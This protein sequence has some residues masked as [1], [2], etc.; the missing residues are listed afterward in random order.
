MSSAFRYIVLAMSLVF[1]LT[2]AGGF[3]FSAKKLVHDLG[4]HKQQHLSTTDHAPSE[5]FAAKLSSVSSNNVDAST[6]ELEHQ[7][8]HAVG[9]MQL[10]TVA[11][12]N[13]FW[14]PASHISSLLTHTHSLPV[15]LLEAPFRPPR[16]TDSN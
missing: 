15:V 4:H 16:A 12:S 2:S 14:A 8:L 13:I 7:L 3:G 11:M 1:F 9:A 10:F 5:L 6:A